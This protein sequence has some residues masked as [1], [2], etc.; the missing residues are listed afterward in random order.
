MSQ[1]R[2]CIFFNFNTKWNLC[3]DSFDPSKALDTASLRWLRH[4]EIPAAVPLDSSISFADLADK[5]HLSERTLTRIVRHA[6]TNNIFVES[7][8]EHVSHTS[9][10]IQLARTE[11]PIRGVVGHQSEV[12]FPAAAKMV[13]AHE[14]FGTDEESA[15]HAPFQL[16]FDTKDRALD[17]VANDPVASARF[18]ESMK[19]G[20]S[21][22][23][24]SVVSTV[25]GFDWSGLGEAVVVD[26]SI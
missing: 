16:A 7:P 6:M 9:L 1:S 5:V 2:V 11:N 3:T 12:V 13:E 25:K 20:A 4:Y 17:W 19:G 22:G 15:T 18:A 21:S 8:P 24:F 14:L 10:S 26:V 23:P